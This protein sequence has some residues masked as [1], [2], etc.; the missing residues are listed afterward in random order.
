MS[1]KVILHIL[2]LVKTYDQ[3]S[4]ILLRYC[5]I[6]GINELLNKFLDAIFLRFFSILLRRLHF[7][8]NQLD[9]WY[10][11]WFCSSHWR[12]TLLLYLL[13]MLRLD[14]ILLIVLIM[15]WKNHCASTFYH[16]VMI[17]L[18]DLNIILIGWNYLIICGELVP[19]DFFLQ[20][21]K[22]TP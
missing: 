10:R 12:F 14:Q 6:T 16:I 20:G 8:I 9:I 22:C 17:L 7:L 15:A 19:H 2:V 11:G 3:N 4:S 18:F 1:V 13:L 21:V 5:I